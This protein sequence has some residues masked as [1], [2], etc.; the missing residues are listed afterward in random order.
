[1]LLV[2]STTLIKEAGRM[3]PPY[4]KNVEPMC[5]PR[6][7]SHSPSLALPRFVGHQS[8]LFALVA[9]NKRKFGCCCLSF[10]RII[11]T[12]LSNLLDFNE[13]IFFDFN[14]Y[15]SDHCGVLIAKVI[16]QLTYRESNDG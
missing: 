4:L 14:E 3:T 7:R 5:D 11:L 10:C 15:N 8:S 1:M 2:L 13:Y 6:S 12:V 16:K 9:S